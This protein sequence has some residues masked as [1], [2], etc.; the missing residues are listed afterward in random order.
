MRSFDHVQ[1][2]LFYSICVPIITY[3]SDVVEY[4]SRDLESLHVAVND[5]IHL[6]TTSGRVS[7]LF[8]DP[9]GSCL[10]P[11]FSPNAKPILK[12]NSLIL[13]FGNAFLFDLSHTW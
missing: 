11:R 4:H 1:M 5:E 12:A 7:G 8:V 3:A 10:L 13:V 2:K 9:L 6:P